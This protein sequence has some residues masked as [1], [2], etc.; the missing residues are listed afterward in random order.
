MTA[1]EAAM[2]A[3]RKVVMMM[4]ITAVTVIMVQLPFPDFE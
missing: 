3:V 4:E 1:G 2:M